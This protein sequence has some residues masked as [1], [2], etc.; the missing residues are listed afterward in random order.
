MHMKKNVCHRE[1]NY[2]V[3]VIIDECYYS[4]VGIEFLLKQAGSELDVVSFP[5]VRSFAVWYQYAM[6][7]IDTIVIYVHDRYYTID[8]KMAS[9]LVFDLDYYEILKCD[10]IFI[11]DDLPHITHLCAVKLQLFNLV[12]GRGPI[13]V[14][15]ERLRNFVKLGTAEPLFYRKCQNYFSSGSNKS[16][17]ELSRA[18]VA[19]IDNI[20]NGRTIQASCELSSR[21]YKT[22]AIQRGSALK[23]M[24]MRTVQDLIKYKYLVVLLYFGRGYVDF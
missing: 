11:S 14:I 24:G 9:F 5:D 2:Y 19:E 6:E 8:D 3:N 17:Y 4:R 23:K 10:V 20:L 22:H 12:N 16:K 7:K 18:E 1:L 21:A 15:K 13:A